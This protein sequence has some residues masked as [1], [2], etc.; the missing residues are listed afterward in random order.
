MGPILNTRILPT[1]HDYE[2]YLVIDSIWDAIENSITTASRPSYTTQVTRAVGLSNSYECNI[3]Y[4]NSEGLATYSTEYLN[5]E[6]YWPLVTP[7]FPSCMR[8]MEHTSIH[9]K[10]N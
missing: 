8:Y 1:L 4:N 9:T 10:L 2:D 3:T 7:Y 6:V 5:T